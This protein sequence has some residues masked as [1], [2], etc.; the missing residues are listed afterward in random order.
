MCSIPSTPPAM[1]SMASSGVATWAKTRRPRA[2][3]RREVASPLGGTRHQHDVLLVGHAHD[4][5]DAIAKVGLPVAD[6]LLCGELVGT[7]T[8]AGTEQGVDVGVPE[9]REEPPAPTVND[10]STY[11]TIVGPTHR[12]DDAGIDDDLGR[13]SWGAP[14][15]S[16]S[17]TSS[18]TRRSVRRAAHR[19]PSARGRRMTSTTAPTGL[20]RLPAGGRHCAR[21]C[22]TSGGSP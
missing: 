15:P 3:R 13:R 1:H 10:R 2:W 6:Q 20:A 14:V 7:D 9:P 21:S 12:G 11:G 19:V 17:V 5:R 8:S 4:R 22:R 16:R 18:S